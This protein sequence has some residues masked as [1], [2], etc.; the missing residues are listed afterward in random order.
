MAM[1]LGY[2]VIFGA[3]GFWLPNDPRGSWSD[4]VVHTIKRSDWQQ[5]TL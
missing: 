2:H 3:Y 5:R 1:I 4:F